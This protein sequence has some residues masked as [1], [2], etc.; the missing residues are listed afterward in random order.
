M[1]I[2]TQY[3]F[4]NPDELYTDGEGG[5][6][7]LKPRKNGQIAVMGLLDGDGIEEDHLV[8]ENKNQFEYEVELRKKALTAILQQVGKNFLV[9]QKKSMPEG[10]RL[11][12][13]GSHAQTYCMSRERSQFPDPAR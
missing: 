3:E 9:S 11:P 6:S 7:T 5:Y 12:C 2:L 1:I 10:K 13:G 8:R 4:K